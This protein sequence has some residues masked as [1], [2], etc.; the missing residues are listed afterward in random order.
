M[1]RSRRYVRHSVFMPMDRGHLAKREN[2]PTYRSRGDRLAGPKTKSALNLEVLSRSFAPVRD[3]LVFDDLPKRVATRKK[4]SKRGK[5]S[6]KP[7]R[8]KAAKRTTPKQAKSKVRRAVGG[9]AKPMAKKQ[10]PSKMAARKAPRKAPRQVVEVPVEDTIIDVIEEPAPGVVVVT[11]YE[12]IQTATPV[13]S[14]REPK[15]DAGPETEEQ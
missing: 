10:R 12:T 15:P 2:T 7:A 13:S 1:R 5:A 3:F 14:D 4:S 8:K 11:E 9:A 6:A